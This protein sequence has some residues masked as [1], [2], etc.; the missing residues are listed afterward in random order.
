MMKMM[1]ENEKFQGL[2][3]GVKEDLGPGT[4]PQA[5][6][7]QISFSGSL[8]QALFVMKNLFS[9]RKVA[10]GA[11][12]CEETVFWYWSGAVGTLFC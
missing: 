7:F 1:Q 10:A 2:G 3:W 9:V 11:F 4:L 12:S 8:P 5:P 6:F